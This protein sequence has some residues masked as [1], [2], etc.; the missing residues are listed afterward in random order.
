MASNAK[1]YQLMHLKDLISNLS[2]CPSLLTDSD[3]NKYA[4]IN[5]DLKF[6]EEKNNCGKY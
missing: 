1:S 5:I 2:G 6:N 4:I 3:V